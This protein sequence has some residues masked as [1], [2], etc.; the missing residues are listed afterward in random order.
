MLASGQVFG[1]FTGGSD[2]RGSSTQIILD[3]PLEV[4]KGQ[5]Y[6]LSIAIEGEKRQ[7]TGQRAANRPRKTDLGRH[8]A[9][10]YVRA[11][12][13]FDTF[14]GVLPIR[15]EFPDC[16]GMIT[17]KKTSALS[18]PFLDQADTIII[19]SNRQWGSIT[20]LPDQFPV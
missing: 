9:V 13:L 11:S 19:T 12:I 5:S 1:D 3:Q 10:V 6:G 16:T 7:G 15:P 4:E 18:F 8:S 14:E 2:Y 20:Q 17:R